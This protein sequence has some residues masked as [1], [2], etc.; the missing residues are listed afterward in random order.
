MQ[1]DFNDWPGNHFNLEELIRPY[2]DSFFNI[3]YKYREIFSEP[4]FD[5][6]ENTKKSESAGSTMDNRKVYKIKYNVNLLA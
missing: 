2:N 1:F 4:R 3:R 5:Y 6:L